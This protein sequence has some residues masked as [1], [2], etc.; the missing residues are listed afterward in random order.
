M[1]LPSAQT[2]KTATTS[3]T[4]SGYRAAPGSSAYYCSLFAAP[5]AAADIDLVFAFRQELQH[6]LDSS[7]EPT[8]ARLRLQWWKEAL[9]RCS[10][11]ACEHPLT[12]ALVDPIRRHPLPVGLFHAMSEAAEQVHG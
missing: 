7:S 3:Q 5:E 1:K 10:E 6:I 11:G 2:G 4:R 12:R 9:T 8:V